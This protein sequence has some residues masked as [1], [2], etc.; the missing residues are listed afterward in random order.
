MNVYGHVL[1]IADALVR[2]LAVDEKI[3]HVRIGV[4][5]LALHNEPAILLKDG[6]SIAILCID[7]GSRFF[8]RP[9]IVVCGRIASPAVSNVVAVVIFGNCQAHTLIDG[10]FVNSHRQNPD[11]RPVHDIHN[12]RDLP[13]RVATRTA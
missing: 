2:E 3:L 1:G 12:H 13:Q 4:G 5:V 6:E 9:G 7:A 10:F 11:S 8:I